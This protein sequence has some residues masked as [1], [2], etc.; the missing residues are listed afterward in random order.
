MG[1]R[2]KENA[3]VCVVKSDC[4]HI[5]SLD[6]SDLMTKGLSVEHTMG[7]LKVCICGIELF[8]YSS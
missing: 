3:S 4:L 5:S 2:G 6:V 1:G 7:M 8:M